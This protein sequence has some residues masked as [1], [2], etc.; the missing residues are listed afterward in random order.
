MCVCALV[1]FW[2]QK[3][4]SCAG[5]EYITLDFFPHCLLYIYTCTCGSMHC[6]ILYSLYIFSILALE[7]S[8]T[9]SWRDREKRERG[10]EGGGGGER[11]GKGKRG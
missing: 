9:N 3:K 2:E 7:A 4:N 5:I 8:G 11:G 6:S 1:K 10:R